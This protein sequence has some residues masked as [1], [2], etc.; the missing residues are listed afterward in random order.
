MD[1]SEKQR[2]MWIN[3][4]CHK[5]SK[6]AWKEH[7]KVCLLLRHYRQIFLL[8]RLV[9]R[10]VFAMHV[11]NPCTLSNEDWCVENL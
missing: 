9:C 8:A 3:K 7:H 2:G 5:I 1:E 11:D 10:V 6:D 4:I